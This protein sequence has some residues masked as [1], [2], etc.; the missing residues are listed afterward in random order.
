M[1]LT[2]I[3][4]GGDALTRANPINVENYFTAQRAPDMWFGDELP[5]TYQDYLNDPQV[6]QARAFVAY[7][8]LQT[9]A[10]AEQR[11]TLM[12]A[13]PKQRKQF[14]KQYAAAMA[15]QHG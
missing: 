10:Q 6:K 12:S 1:D 4:F 14:A 7:Q 8:I 9:V 3:L 5:P 15:Q 13:S 11:K 2:H